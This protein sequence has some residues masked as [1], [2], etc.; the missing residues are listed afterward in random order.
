MTEASVCSYLLAD[1]LALTL[2]YGHELWVLTQKMRHVVLDARDEN[3]LPLK[4]VWAPPER[5]GE[6]LDL[7]GATPSH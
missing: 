7:S 2:T 5:Q 6:N 4:A 3:E 1:L